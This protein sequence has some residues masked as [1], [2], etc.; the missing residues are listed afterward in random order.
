MFK[1]ALLNNTS[2]IPIDYLHDTFWACSASDK[3]K[4]LF[5]KLAHE[6]IIAIFAPQLSKKLCK[7]RTELKWWMP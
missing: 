3:Y 7:Q 1:Y 4:T 5:R 6:Q 2:L